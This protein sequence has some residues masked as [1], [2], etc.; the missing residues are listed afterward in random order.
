MDELENRSDDEDEVDKQ[1]DEKPESATDSKQQKDLKQEDLSNLSTNDTSRDESLVENS[2]QPAL[3]INNNDA[4]EI[5]ELAD[6][7]DEEMLINNNKCFK[8]FRD[9][10]LVKPAD[11]YDSDES[12]AVSVTTSTIM[13]PKLVRAKVRGNLLKRQKVEARRVR[14]KGESA[15]KTMA[16][17]DIREDIKSNFD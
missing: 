3:N 12:E 4:A 17:R 8:A 14:N 13:D 16:L 15:L 1:T 7:F 5:D 11:E 10:P 9:N 6:H 2:P